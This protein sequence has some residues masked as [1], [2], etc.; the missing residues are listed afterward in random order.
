IAPPQPAPLPRVLPFAARRE[1]LRL[2]DDILATLHQ[3][4]EQEFGD[5]SEHILSETGRRWGAAAMQAF[6]ARA[7]E[8][9]GAAPE[10][11]HIGVLLATW[12]WPRRAGGWGAATFDFRRAAQRLLIA[13]VRN[14]A[15]ARAVSASPQREQGSKPVCHLYAGYFAG[16][17][18]ALAK[19]DL[20]SVELQ[21][22]AAGA[23]SCQFLFSTPAHVQQ[24]RQWRDAGE[25]A[26]AIV[27]KL[28]EPHEA[29]R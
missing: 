12:W 20:A 5:K 1:G 4:I 3:A 26:A 29:A 27:R 15:E 18:G 16:G 25:P 10:A 28:A 21:C 14:C 9:L 2:S 13:E 23:D 7:P 22:H 19:R 8:Q 24:A 6:L 11:V 17:L